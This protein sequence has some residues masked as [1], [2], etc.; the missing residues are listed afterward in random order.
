MGLFD[1]MAKAVVHV[2]VSPVAVVADVVTLGGVL[3]ERGQ[4][5][6]GSLIEALEDDFDEMV[7]GDD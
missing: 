1:G 5:H 3:T 2:A 7:D 6:T 4:S